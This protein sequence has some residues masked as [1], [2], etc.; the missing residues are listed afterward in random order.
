MVHPNVA[1]TFDMIDDEGRILP[2]KLRPISIQWQPMSMTA[3]P[4]EPKRPA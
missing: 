2:M 1:R 3:P 4:P